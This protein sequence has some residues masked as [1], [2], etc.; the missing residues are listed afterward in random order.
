MQDLA[1]LSLRQ[2]LPAPSPSE[3][4]SPYVEAALDAIFFHMAPTL[5]SGI[6]LADL[7]REA[8]VRFL[9]SSLCVNGVFIPLG[10]RPLTQK[11]IATFFE[12]WE[13]E[14]D[15]E[16][17]LREVYGYKGRSTGSERMN[18]SYD[19]NLNKLI[20]RTRKLLEDTLAP[21]GWG[22]NFEWFVFDPKKKVW[23]LW[24]LRPEGDLEPFPSL[25]YDSPS[26]VTI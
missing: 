2:L 22:S 20:S 12:D 9:G 18:Q 5:G 26:L 10:S 7:S 24:N 1:P 4:L 6:S 13:R 11:L 21:L 8:D 19:C 3:K 15:R 25:L 17:I 14:A 16:T 23:K